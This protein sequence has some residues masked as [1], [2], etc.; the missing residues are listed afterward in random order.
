MSGVTS[1]ADKRLEFYRNLAQQDI[2]LACLLFA[3]DICDWTP[4]YHQIYHIKEMLSNQRVLN[5]LPPRS[6][7]TSET[8]LVDLF[9]CVINPWEELRLYCPKKEQGKEAMRYIYNWINESSILHSF[10]RKHNGKPVL[11]HERFEFANM[12]IGEVHSVAAKV[13]GHNATIAR[14]EEFDD[15]KFEWFSEKVMRRIA[16][17]NKNG[18]PTRIRITGTIKGQENI[19]RMVTE[20]GLS[21]QYK[22][23]MVHPVM[24]ILDVHAMIECGA[25]DPDAVEQQRLT[26]P[27]DEWARSM[28]LKFTEATNFIYSRYLRESMKAAMEWDIPLDGIDPYRDGYYQT[29]GKIAIGFDC[30]HS[31]QSKESSV[32]SLQVVEEIGDW[33]RWIYAKKWAPDVDESQLQDEVFEIFRFFKPDG[34]YGDAL[35]ANTIQSINKRLWREGISFLNPEEHPENNASNWKRWYFSPLWNTGKEKHF[36]YSSLRNGVHGGKFFFPYYDAKDTRPIAIICKQTIQSILNIRQETTAG[37]YP[38]YYGASNEHGDDHADALG[39]AC[40]W[41]DDHRDIQVNYKLVEGHGE[42]KMITGLK[43]TRLSSR[44]MDDF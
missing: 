13:E 36:Y 15:W 25:L 17:P 10:L 34:G 5:V 35:Q 38:R 6:G 4:R 32:Y 28:L 14:L 23:L 12:S 37:Q 43:R 40:R 20:K 7:K 21:S 39:M 3:K 24:G 11:S 2:V 1:K 44:I 9:D 19:F 41:L 18:L 31:G 42:H 29:C 26:M 8:E 27:P 30:G 16:A 22:N 33:R